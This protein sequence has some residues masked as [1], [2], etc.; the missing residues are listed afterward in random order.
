[1]IIWMRI[2]TYGMSDT[3]KV[4]AQNEDAFLRDDAH[5]VYAVADGLGGLPEGARASNLAILGLEESL[6][7]AGNGDCLD[8]A[9]TFC[10]INRRI[11]VEGRALGGGLGMGTTLTVMRLVENTVRIAHIG[12]CAVLLIRDG[13][14]T[15][16]TADHTMANEILARRKAGEA[17]THLPEYFFHT[18]TRC[19]GQ[20]AS[21][22]PDM[23]CEG[24]QAG[25]R[26]L[27]CSDGISKILDADD[28]LSES[29]RAATPDEFVRRIIELA[30]TLGGPDNA[31]GVA[32]FVEAD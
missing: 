11:H 17:E 26:L 23:I 14:A 25:D 8:M 6:H 22:E 5:R 13:V 27:V 7:E 9:E 24:L 29:R 28:I 20:H 1:M 10:R 21:I 31:T 32:V 4:R 19:M 12:D 18:L 30:N 15:Q 3:G 2:S 16:L